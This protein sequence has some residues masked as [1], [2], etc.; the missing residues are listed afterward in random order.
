MERAFYYSL[1]SSC[2][3]INKRDSSLF[4]NVPFYFASKAKAGRLMSYFIDVSVSFV[5][6][7]RFKVLS[8]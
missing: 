4:E 2:R 6:S 3:S 8:N 7:Q 5:T 1:I